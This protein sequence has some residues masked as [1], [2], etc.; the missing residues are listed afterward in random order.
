L[1]QRDQLLNLQVFLLSQCLYFCLYTHFQVHSNS[2]RYSKEEKANFL[3]HFFLNQWHHRTVYNILNNFNAEIKILGEVNW[4]EILHSL[5][6]RNTIP[7]NVEV[8]L[9]KF[10]YI[11]A[12][13]CFQSFWDIGSD[14][15]GS[16]CWG[17]I[18][19]ALWLT[20]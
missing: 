12:L 7:L 20:R 5:K 14:L 19:K 13:R 3:T 18:L 10:R 1:S 9:F 6:S 4:G 8:N 17:R 2:S 11:P 16:S 15:F